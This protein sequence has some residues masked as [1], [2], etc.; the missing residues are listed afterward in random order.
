MKQEQ[1]FIRIT[2]QDARKWKRA[3]RNQKYDVQKKMGTELGK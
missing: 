1:N 3:F 2:K